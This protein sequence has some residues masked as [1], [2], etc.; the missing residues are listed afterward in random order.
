M[1]ILCDF[2]HSDLWLSHHLIFEKTLGH[3][4]FRPRGIEWMELGYYYD[5]NHDV[6]RQFLVD[7]LFTLED[8]VKYPS[9]RL[10]PDGSADSRVRASMDTLNGSL[11]YPLFQTLSLE[12][13]KDTPI[14]VIMPTIDENQMPWL[15]LRDHYKPEAKL[16]R[17][18]G[19]VRGWASLHPAYQNILT[20][21]VQTYK[22]VQVPNKQLY[23]Q[24][25]DVDKTFQPWEMKDFRKITSFMPGFRNV[26]ELVQFYE[27]HDLSGFDFIDYGHFSVNGFL[28]T[29]E[30]YAEELRKT[31]LVW[32]VKPG[33]DGF[34]H[35]LHSAIAVGRPIITVANDYE[36]TIAWPILEDGVTCILI[37]D[38]PEENS[39]KI[40]SF[41]DPG[42]L[43]TMGAK[44]ARRFR[45]MI[46]YDREALEIERF[47][48]RL[49]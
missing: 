15:R 34:G 18:Q 16:A 17:E 29:K 2:H 37:G 24:K 33:G 27:R 30:R 39:N 26:P 19:N 43:S 4:I 9:C 47:L 7:S 46:H 14:D 48:E 12:E 5:K 21:D 8:V 10:K 25:I 44:A 22:N 11:S 3:K 6:A 38:N 35:V 40:R 13:F 41:S 20:S 42:K 23:H 49:L 45:E 32:H 36:E 1:N 31:T 28:S